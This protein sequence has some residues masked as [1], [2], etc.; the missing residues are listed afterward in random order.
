MASRIPTLAMALLCVANVAR[1]E[2]GEPFPR[3]PKASPSPFDRLSI[4]E[5]EEL[6]VL[7]P[8]RVAN[9]LLHAK[10]TFN[11]QFPFRSEADWT[12]TRYKVV[13]LPGK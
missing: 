8:L 11:A 4:G 9:S 5:L 13:A 12:R 7:Y 3:K 6:V 1:A 10:R 2:A